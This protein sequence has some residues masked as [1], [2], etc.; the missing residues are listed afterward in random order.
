MD[1]DSIPPHLDQSIPDNCSI[2]L[3]ILQY[4]FYR[5]GQI[6]IYAPDGIRLENIGYGIKRDDIESSTYRLKEQI[7]LMECLL[8]N[9]SNRLELPAQAVSALADL[10]Y[11]MQKFCWEYI[12]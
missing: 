8:G 4:F 11:R 10:L 2:N 1:T 12:K 5:S 9:L 3:D 6:E 7:Y